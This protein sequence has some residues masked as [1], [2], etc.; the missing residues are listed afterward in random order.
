[1]NRTIETGRDNVLEIYNGKVQELLDKAKE[2]AASRGLL[3]QLEGELDWLGNFFHCGESRGDNRTPNEKTHTILSYDFAPY[4][5]SFQLYFVEPD[6]TEK[7]DMNGGLIYEGPTSPADG[8][9]PSLTV[10]L[11]SKE[12]WFVHT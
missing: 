2:F 7:A 8:Q 4:S 11:T 6:G 12:G 1:M 3:K 5:F 9:L 10:S